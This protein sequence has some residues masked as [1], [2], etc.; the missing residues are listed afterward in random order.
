MIPKERYG[1]HE[2]HCCV[3]HGCKYGN[4]DC[5]VFSG[6]IIQ[7]YGCEDCP[8]YFKPGFSHIINVSEEQFTPIQEG[9]Q[10]YFIFVTKDYDVEKGHTM[11]FKSGDKTVTRVISRVDNPQT[12]NIGYSIVSFNDNIHNIESDRY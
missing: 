8:Q 11:V 7:K 9:K 5:P 6:E 2:T 10:T 4:E 12:L 1:V 3:H